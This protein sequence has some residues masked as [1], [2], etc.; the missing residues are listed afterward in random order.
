MESINSR[1]NE[2]AKHYNLNSYADF[3]K[4]TGISHQ[5]TS[6]YLKGRQKPDADRLAMIIESFDEVDPDWLLTGRGNMLKKDNSGFGSLDGDG[7]SEE[8][9]QI[10]VDGL[11][12]HEDTVLQNPVV[13]TWYKNKML[14][15]E[16]NL[17]KSLKDTKDKS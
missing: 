16:N 6:N 14:E 15:C 1:L 10:V 13:N 17:L 4:R 5:T 9:I 12:N 7:F 3:S 8:K 2:I 11:I